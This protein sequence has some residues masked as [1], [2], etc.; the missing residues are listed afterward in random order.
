MLH[1]HKSLRTDHA[2]GNVIHL[3]LVYIIDMTI[4]DG[5]KKVRYQLLLGHLAL[6]I[7]VWHK[8]PLTFRL[9][10]IISEFV[11]LEGIVMHKLSHGFLRNVD[12]RAVN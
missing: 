1:T 6:G 8:W 4:V 2:S 7:R 12:L 5:I 10:Y 9:F 3:R 11:Y